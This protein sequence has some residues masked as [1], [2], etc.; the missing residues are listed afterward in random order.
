MIQV[1]LLP[2]EHRPARGTPVARFAA[3]VSGVV[4]VVGTG[5]WYAYTHFVE[6]A[7]AQ[8]VV[9]LRTEEASSKEEQRKRSVA[10]QREIDEYTQRRRAIQTINRHRVLWS[11]K[12][13]Q[14]FDLVAGRGADAGYTAWLDELEV[15][16]Q[17]ATRRPAGG[18]G[19]PTS[20]G[21]LFK[22]AGD[23][24]MEAAN[25]APAQNSAFYKALTGDP[26]TTRR[27][28]EFFQDFAS[29]SNPTIAVL[30]AH[31]KENLTPPV[32][33]AFRYELRLRPPEMDDPRKPSPRKK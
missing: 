31:E 19:L 20:D 15:P 22:F 5:C 7:R 6:L 8:E 33:G 10:L 30:P 17:V 4:L 3:I 9:S 12:L 2:P 27:P 29:I 24:A 18:A 28:S 25:D 21:G 1:N 32:V 14:F 13:D 11:R 23:L 26:D 16:T